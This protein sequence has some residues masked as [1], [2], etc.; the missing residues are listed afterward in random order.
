M[1]R[2]ISSQ[3]TKSA[4]AHLLK[5][6]GETGERAPTQQTFL[7]GMLAGLKGL[8][9]LRH[10][11]AAEVDEAVS[12]KLLLAEQRRPAVS[13]SPWLLAVVFGDR[14]AFARAAQGRAG[15]ETAPVDLAPAG[16][17]DGC[18][19]TPATSKTITSAGLARPRQASRDACADGGGRAPWQRSDDARKR[20]R[21]AL[22]AASTS[23]LASL[24]EKGA[25]V[26]T[27]A[28]RAAVTARRYWR[29][30]Q[31][32]R[33][34]GRGHLRRRGAASCATC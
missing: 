13:V 32:R 8:A 15:Y 20:L 26:N 3:G 18:W 7:D 2:R 4:V 33:S 29:P 28:A 25:I 17:A 24:A 12:T 23:S 27:L 31:R 34:P 21:A 30:W 10:P 11:R 14:E 16:A 1:I 22:L 6:L 19:W 5:A 9:R